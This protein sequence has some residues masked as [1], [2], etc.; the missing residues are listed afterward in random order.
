MMVARKSVL[1]LGIALSLF[2]LRS[3]PAHAQAI[4]DFPAG[5]APRPAYN[6]QS[7]GTPLSSF[8]AGRI[9]QNLRARIHASWAIRAQ[10]LVGTSSSA[11]VPQRR[12]V[13]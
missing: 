13:K 5:G 9:V 10:R 11:L 2:A 4:P 6:P 8:D 3:A 7:L 1:V 12:I